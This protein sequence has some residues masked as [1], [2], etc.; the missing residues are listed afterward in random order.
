ML[1]ENSDFSISAISYRII[2]DSARKI[3]TITPVIQA[4]CTQNQLLIA[5]I[6]VDGHELRPSLKLLLEEGDRSYVV[7]GVKIANP[8]LTSPEDESGSRDYKVTLR[9]HFDGDESH[10]LDE[11]IKVMAP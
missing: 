5:S 6:R 8:L 3:A 10:D 11:H 1:F 4:I 2:Y 9:L 7:P